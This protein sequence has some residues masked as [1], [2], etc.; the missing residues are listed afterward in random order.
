MSMTSRAPSYINDVNQGSGR[1]D[2]R[3]NV[4]LSALTTPI[5]ANCGYKD[6]AC[7]TYFVLYSQWGTATSGQTYSS[8]GGFEEW[9][10]K[11]YPYVVVTKTATTT[12]TR[13]F[14]WTI[15]KSVTP[16]DLEPVHR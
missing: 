7:T 9:K 2:L 16:A 15:D 12:F 14:P 5:P 13:T 1:G 8:D 6:P 11:Q 3:Y 4:P 10:V